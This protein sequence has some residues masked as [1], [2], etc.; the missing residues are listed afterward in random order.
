MRRWTGC[1]RFPSTIT[2]GEPAGARDG[3]GRARRVGIGR[4]VR[5]AIALHL[6]PSVSYLVLSALVMLTLEWHLSLVVLAFAGGAGAHRRLGL[7]RTDRSRA[8]AR[9]ALGARLRSPQRGAFRNRG[10]PQLR[11]GGGREAALRRRR[12]RRERHRSARR[13]SRREGECIEECDEGGRTRH[14]A[15]ARR[16]SR[17]PSRDFARHARGVRRLRRRRVL[18]GAV[19]HRH[20]SGRS[21]GERRAGSPSPRSSMPSTSLGDA[22]DA[23]D[24]LVASAATSPSTT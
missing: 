4:G 16:R 11:Q 8:S 14:R 22:H 7:A 10:G 21:Q 20:V 24:S 15:R 9:V 12:E 23:H 19:A 6:V 3:A 17:R 1:T 5:G 18:A 13:A 2:G